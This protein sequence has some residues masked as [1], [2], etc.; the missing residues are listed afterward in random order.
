MDN[1]YWIN[2]LRTEVMPIL[3]QSINPQKVLLFGSRAKGN[4]DP[5]SDIDIIIVSDYFRDIH[6]LKRMTFV[7]KK[8]RFPK[9]ID[10]LCYTPEEFEKIQK[11]SVVVWDA[12]NN[13][14]TLA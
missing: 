14:Y 8:I 10:A 4:N 9:H 13:S 2:R 6:P 3:Q 12:V 7:L 1:E 11:T 5:D